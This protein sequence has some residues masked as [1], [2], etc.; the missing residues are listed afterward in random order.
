MQKKIKQ[1]VCLLKKKHEIGRKIEREER[2]QFGFSNCVTIKWV[3][4]FD[5]L[6]CVAVYFT[7]L[8]RF[9]C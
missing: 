6:I 3:T 8:L 9:R 2:A 7:A 5:K 1:N 4:N